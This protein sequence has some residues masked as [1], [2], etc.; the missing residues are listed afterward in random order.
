MEYLLVSA[1]GTLPVV[2]FTN[3]GTGNSR[4]AWVCETAQVARERMA[5]LEAMPHIADVCLV[6]AT[7]K[8]AI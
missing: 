7:V 8:E 5:E 6:D 2:M 4:E 3:T 1:L